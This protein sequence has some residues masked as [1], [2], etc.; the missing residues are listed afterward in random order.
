M[1]LT[2]EGAGELQTDMTMATDGFTAW[3]HALPV[4][5]GKDI[6]EFVAKSDTFYTPTLLVAYGGPWG[7]LYY[8][9]TANPH[10]DP[11]L[12]RFV[13]HESLDRMARR[14]PVDLAGR[15]P[16]PDVAHG[17]A[18]VLRAGG[19]VSLGA[20][21]QLQGLGPHWEIWAMAGEG[22]TQKNWAMTP[23]EALRASTILAAEKLGFEPDLGS[24]EAGKLA[25]FM[26]LDAEPARRHPQHAED[27]LGRQERR[28]VGG[29]DDEEGLAERRAAA[30]VLLEEVSAASAR[31]DSR[32][33]LSHRLCRNEEALQVGLPHRRRDVPRRRDD[34]PAAGVRRAAAAGR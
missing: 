9:Q 23:M 12:N 21:G 14:H 32:A 6:V 34:H 16:L 3:E 22:A 19:N 26:V 31:A 27:P 5:L 20:H 13:P 25:D 1:L 2:A 10:D 33:A 18:E 8:W 30:D 15:V 29:R 28:D 4:A 7:E 24:I 17:A 11:K